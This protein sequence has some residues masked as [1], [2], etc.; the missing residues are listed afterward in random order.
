MGSLGCIS[1]I[2]SGRGHFAGR[3]RRSEKPAGI[4][5]SLPDKHP[6]KIFYKINIKSMEKK[7]GKLRVGLQI[8]ANLGNLFLSAYL[9]CAESLL[10]QDFFYPMNMVALQL[11]Q[12][13]FYGS[14]AG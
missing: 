4:G 13:L 10:H 9:I 2:F 6:R 7:I 11:D 1:I 12:A 5:K 14:A 3:L 8:H